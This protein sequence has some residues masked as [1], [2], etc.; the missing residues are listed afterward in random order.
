ML[1]K[2][3]ESDLKLGKCLM[4]YTWHVWQENELHYRAILQVCR[5]YEEGWLWF[6]EAHVKT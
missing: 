2:F 5:D 4:D 6:S 1:H 3:K